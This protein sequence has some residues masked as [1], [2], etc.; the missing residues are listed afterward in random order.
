M[1]GGADGFVFGRGLERPT[2][3]LLLQQLAPPSTPA[4]SP[5][6]LLPTLRPGRAH[7]PPD[8]PGRKAPWHPSQTRSRRPAPLPCRPRQ[9]L[10]RALACVFKASRGGSHA[11]GTC[12]LGDVSEAQARGAPAGDR[13]LAC[14]AVPR[15]SEPA[16]RVS[17]QH[18]ACARA[19]TA[20]LARPRLRPRVAPGQ[21]GAGARGAVAPHLPNSRPRRWRRWRREGSSRP[22]PLGGPSPPAPRWGD[23]VLVG[24]GAEGRRLAR[25]RRAD[26]PA[27]VSHAGGAEPSRW[28]GQTSSGQGLAK[29]GVMCSSDP[30]ALSRAKG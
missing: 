9:W 24:S 13:E 21:R 11:A 5:A 17:K 1:E 29:V 10:R 7:R 6:T 23:W 14:T 26:R 12:G 18:P 28:R 15:A 27:S 19:R 3:N 2:P 8:I 20:R 4:P 25:V 22:W 16:L 30:F